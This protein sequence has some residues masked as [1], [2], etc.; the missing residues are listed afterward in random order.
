MKSFLKTFLLFLTP[1]STAG[2]QMEETSVCPPLLVGDASSSRGF[3]LASLEEHPS[4]TQGKLVPLPNLSTSGVSFRDGI[5]H[6]KFFSIPMSQCMGF[7]LV[8][9]SLVGEG[10]RGR[11]RR[12]SSTRTYVI[13][14]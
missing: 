12:R 5:A 1:K 2:A 14:F 11:Q 8:C 6:P 4:E 3:I 9:V 13:S 7:T 10:T